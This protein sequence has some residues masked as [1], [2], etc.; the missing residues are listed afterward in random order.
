[1]NCHNNL[2]SPSGEDISF[3]INWRTSMMANSARDPYWHAAVRREVMDHPESRA[4]IENECSTCHMPMAH[5][6]AKTMGQMSQVF[7]NLPANQALTQ[8]NMLAVD[9]VSCTTCHQ[10]KNDNF[11]ERESFVGGFLIDTEKPLGQ[12]EI[13]GPYPVDLGRSRIMHSS[14]GFIQMESKHLIESELCAT[15]HTLY[16]HTLGPG[17]EVIGELPEQVPYLEWKH[18]SFL[19]NQSCQSCHMPVVDGS[20]PISSVWGQ[21]REE[22]SR[23]SFRGGNFFMQSI[24]NRYRDELGVQALPQEMDAAINRTI[25]HL[26]TKSA[27]ISI[28]NA[29]VIGNELIADVEI[30]NLAGHKLPTAYPSRRVWIRFTVTDRNDHVL[31]ESGAVMP[32]GSIRGNDNDR[33]NGQYEQHYGEI[34]GEDQVQI[35]EAILADPQGRV[36]TGLLTAIRYIK[37]NRILPKGFDKFTANEDIAVKG[38]ADNDIDFTGGGD[39]V[40]Y[41]V[42]LQDLNGPIQINAAL[43]YQPIAYRW[44]Q[45]LDSYEASETQKFVNYYNSMSG[46]SSV[47]LTSVKMS[48]N[49]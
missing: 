27:I 34:T 12:R 47:V 30:E 4:V 1:M 3:G 37:D 2:V 42:K 28:A 6:Q 25:K 26:E 9:G 36:T 23:H 16:T 5:Y 38:S 7:A 31:F 35:Y 22:V 43:Y 41:R 48:V 29:E 40:R 39:R 8:Q 17:G 20:T 21:A 45:N 32:D 18:S 14:S 11:G 33:E 10:I 19:N 44:A 24:L 46:H 13:F 49:N 15:C